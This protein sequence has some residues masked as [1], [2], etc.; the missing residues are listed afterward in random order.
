MADIT[1][2]MAH[3]HTHKKSFQIGQT[4]WLNWQNGKTGQ[5]AMHVS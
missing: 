4:S 1:R 5:T 3:T 2:L